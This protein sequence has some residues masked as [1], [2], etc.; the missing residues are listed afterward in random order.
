MSCT[1][2]NATISNGSLTTGVMFDKV[3]FL[4]FQYS[5]HRCSEYLKFKNVTLS[6]N[7]NYN[8]ITTTITLLLIN[9]KIIVTTITNFG[10]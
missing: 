3:T 6:N 7:A 1:N 5:E 10:K 9:Y 4:N 2:V 8:I